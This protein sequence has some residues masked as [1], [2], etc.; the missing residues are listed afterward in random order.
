MSA[1][2]DSH[3]IESRLGFADYS[4]G[5][6]SS[7]PLNRALPWQPLLNALK[8]GDIELARRHYHDLSV[9]NPS[10]RQTVWTEIGALISSA[11]HRA[12][13]KRLKA[14][15]SPAYLFAATNRLAGHRSTAT[16]R[17]NADIPEIIGLRLDL[18]A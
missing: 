9:S 2:I 12:A 7:R 16:V 18:N 5:R 4:S 15:P 11:N 8:Q 10:W 3:H 6:E 1:D 13:L 14:L 17:A